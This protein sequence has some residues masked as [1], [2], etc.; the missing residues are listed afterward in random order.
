M[1]ALTT[2]TGGPCSGHCWA[3]CRWWRARNWCRGSLR[4]ASMPGWQGLVLWSQGRKAST[5]SGS[6]ESRPESPRADLVDRVAAG[7]AA[8]DGRVA[9]PLSRRLTPERRRVVSRRRE[10]ADPAGCG[11]SLSSAA[12]PSVVVLLLSSLAVAPVWGPGGGAGIDSAGAGA[13]SM[14]RP[15][16]RCLE[17]APGLG[18]D[19]SRGIL[20]PGRPVF[21]PC[22]SD[23]ESGLVR[24]TD[25][26]TFRI[27]SQDRLP[28]PTG[29][30]G[31]GGRLRLPAWRK[32]GRVRAVQ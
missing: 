17:N 27:D 22:A 29:H 2:W 26:G 12:W 18:G 15:T 13:A 30:R 19:R 16:F 11:C 24:A 31:Q 10:S 8:S 32:P 14:R 5:G 23:P 3:R 7:R 4:V 1:W 25:D 20:T 21:L 9:P 6:L 28:R